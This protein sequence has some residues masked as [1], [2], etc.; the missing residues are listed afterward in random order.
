VT[1]EAERIQRVMKRNTITE[2]QV[3]QRIQNQWTDEQRIKLADF[4]IGN[5]DKELIIPQIIEI[6]KKIRLNG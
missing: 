3:R 5:N 4:V 2:E 6:D 1:D